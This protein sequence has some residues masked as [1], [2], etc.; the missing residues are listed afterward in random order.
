MRHLLDGEPAIVVL[1][2]LGSDLTGSP[3]PTGW[4]WA[5]PDQR[6]CSSTGSAPPPA[7]AR[8][9]ILC[10]DTALSCAVGD[11]LENLPEPRETVA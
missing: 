8:W 7:L 11:V 3:S 9:L 6:H 1:G 5:D 2:R 10:S 4:T